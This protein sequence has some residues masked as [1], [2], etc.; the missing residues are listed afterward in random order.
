M[1]ISGHIIAAEDIGDH[2]KIVGQGM[3]DG[4]AEWQPMRWFTINIPINA[5]NKRAFYVGRK[6]RVTVEP[7]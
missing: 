3:A 6:V 1:K 5:K 7:T 2:L 4:D